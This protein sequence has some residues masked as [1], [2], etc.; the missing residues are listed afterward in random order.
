MPNPVIMV[1]ADDH[2][3]HLVDE[4]G[5]Y[6]RDYD[7]RLVTEPA[8]VRGA[9]QSMLDDGVGL[10][11]VVMD[12]SLLPSDE[13][14]DLR[15]ALVD[16]VSQWCSL[17]PTA[18]GVVVTPFNRFNVDGDVLR[19]ALSL[20]EFDAFLLLP[21][22][23]RDEEFH[24]AVTELLS[25]WGSTVAHPE[26]EAVR[27]VG[28]AD[29]PFIAD[30]SDLLV[31]MGMPF[32]VHEPSSP[33]GH[34]LAAAYDGPPTFPLVDVL[35]RTVIAPESVRDLAAAFYGRPEGIGESGVVDLCIVGAGPAGLAAAVYGASEGLSTVVLESEAIG[36]QAGTSSM[37]RNYLG[38]PRGISGMR[39]ALRA[40]VQALRF[41]TRFLTGWDATG[42]TPSGGAPVHIVH[43]DGGDIQ[44][45][46]VVIAT[47]ASYRRLG[48][49]EI[50]ALSGRG[51]SYGSAMTSAR[52]MTDREVVV[53]G[54]GNSAGQAALHLARFARNVTI[55]VRRDGLEATMSRYLIDEIDANDRIVVHPRCHV[56]AGG[57]EAR[58]EWIDLCDVDSDEV[59]RRSCDGLFLLLGA[60]PRCGWL[61]TDVALDERGF[62][63]TGRDVPPDAW[64]DELPPDNL[65][66]SV[67]GIFAVGDV[68]AG[69]MKRVAA[70]VGEGASV[71]PLIHSYVGA[72]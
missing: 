15:A 21:R 60:E 23:V 8:A 10:A 19:N 26:V 34:E 7:V 33:V 36:G 50:D 5:R 29:D 25:D 9:T 24:T 69:S 13:G 49:P 62:V 35:G 27:V 18:K 56:V 61:P 40:R 48:V 30:I 55:A 47:G 63:L 68:R 57:G 4:F 12:S 28:V 43:T 59:R 3:E 14:A 38:F 51:V 2:G 11:M 22:G 67:P 46:A 65:A 64:L 37:I 17:V 45:R 70:A 39:L 42:L 71:I 6:R 20:G 31:R 1:V 41:G 54:G 16:L 52:E 53:V 32:R 58:L 44:A 72:V 66:T